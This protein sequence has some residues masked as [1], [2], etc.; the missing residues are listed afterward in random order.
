MKVAITGATGFVGRYVV[1][2]LLSNGYEVTCLVR[3]KGKLSKIFKDSVE[4]MEVNFEDKNSLRQ[5][6]EKANPD[7]LIHLIGILVE[8]RKKGETFLKVHYLYSKNIYEVS[9]DLNIKKVVHMSSLGTHKEAPS[10]YHRTKYMAE[11]E[12]IKSG[13]NY[14]IFRPSLI[15]GPQQK[16]FYDMWDIT[17]YVR[18]VALPGGGDYLFQPVDV[19]DVACAFVKALSDRET[20]K[21]ILEL[22]GPDRVSFKRLLKDIFNYWDRKVILLP[23]PKSFMYLGG[24][25]VERLIQPPPFSSDQMLMMW[26]D[27]ICGLDAEAISDGVKKVCQKEPIPYQEA[28]K[29]SLDEFTNNVKG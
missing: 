15:L 19:R 22:C 24:L 29:W 13:L 23:V 11:Q 16:L 17:K 25:V 12:L 21:S 5:A 26:K 10:M 28:L 3:N 27:N 18:I 9:K 1:K 14:T 4:G 2:E 7:Y 6:L 8:N 20:D